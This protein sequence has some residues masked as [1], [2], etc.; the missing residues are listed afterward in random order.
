MVFSPS[1]ELGAGDGLYE[2]VEGLVNDVYK[3]S[4]LIAR[5][6]QHSAL[7]HY[8]VDTHP[9]PPSPNVDSY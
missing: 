3:T 5:L 8:Q 9:P 2:L 4:T 7:P 6:A 1:L